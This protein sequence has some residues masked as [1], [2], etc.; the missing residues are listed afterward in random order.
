M[1]TRKWWATLVA[2]LF[3][4]AAMAVGSGGWGATEWAQ[5]LTLGA[6]L[7]TAY[8]V[9]NQTTPGGVPAGPLQV[10]GGEE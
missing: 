3:T 4:I 8:V 1:P 10:A 6:S 5:V 2:G 7:A 9:S